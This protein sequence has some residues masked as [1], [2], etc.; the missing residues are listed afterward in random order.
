MYLLPELPYA[1][2]S[3]EPFIDSETMHIHHDKHHATYVK[4]L[5]DAIASVTDLSHVAVEDLLKRISEVPES[6]RQKVI[7][8]AG[9]HAN[10]SLYW[11]TLG[12]SHDQEPTGKL[13]EAITE[14]FGS[15]EALKEKMST[16][17]VGRFGSGWSWLAVDNGKLVTLDTANQDSP[18]L[19]GMTPLFG[20]DVW[21]H[22]YYL[23]YRNVRA[24]YVS[25]IWHVVNWHR[26]GQLY[27]QTI[28]KR[29]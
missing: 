23:K 26:I 19:Q 17:A 14:T 5:N 8:N 18:I 27:D 20:I 10:H 12:G 2:E 9:G 11:D 7:N 13:R 3:L 6:I 1:Y 22:A 28:N 16:A 21:E 29:G 4:N 15:I 25:A 24:E